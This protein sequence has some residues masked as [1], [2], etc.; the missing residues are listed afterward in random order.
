MLRDP[1][2]ALAKW[3]SEGQIDKARTRSV[4]E[5]VREITPGQRVALLRS[6]ANARFAP[7]AP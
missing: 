4:A 5:S 7:P 3:R 1:D 2:A 6:V